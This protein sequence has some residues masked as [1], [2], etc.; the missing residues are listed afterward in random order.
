MRKKIIYVILYPIF[1]HTLV[2]FIEKYV[3]TQTPVKLKNCFHKN[4][5]ELEE[6]PN[7]GGLWINDLG[8]KI[9][10][11]D[12]KNLK[13]NQPLKAHFTNSTSN[14]DN[15]HLYPKLSYSDSMKPFSKSKYEFFPLATGKVLQKDIID[16]FYFQQNGSIWV[17]IIPPLMDYYG[18]FSCDKQGMYK[19]SRLKNDNFYARL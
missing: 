19:N 10:L 18:T 13:K 8:I 5:Y 17:V 1:I 2:I 16:Q 9:S 12:V 6:L 11:N 14:L 7:A 4:N 3:L 15:L